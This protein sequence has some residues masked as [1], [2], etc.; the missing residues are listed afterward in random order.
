[1]I[2]PDF[3]SETGLFATNGKHLFDASVYQTDDS[4]SEFHDMVRNLSEKS[5]AAKP[6]EFHHLIAKLASE[7]RLMRLYT[8]NVDG[9]ETSLPPLNTA[10]PLHHKGPWPRTIQLHGGLQKMVCTKCSNISDFEAALFRGAT[11][12]PCPVCIEADKV[13]TDHAGKRSHGVG[14]LRP[15]MLLYN[16]HNPE[17]EAIG[18]VTEADLRTRPDA[19]I[20]VGTKMKV[21]GLKRVVR[22]MCGVVRGRKGGEAIWISR[23]PPPAGKELENC[24]DLIVQGDSDTVAAHARMR[25][26]D[27]DSI[28]Y[29]ECSESDSERAKANDS[30]VKVIIESTS[31]KVRDAASGV[32]IVVEAPAKKAAASALLTPAPSPRSKSIEPMAQLKLFPNLKALGKTDAAEKKE[33]K[34]KPPLKSTAKPLTSKD[35]A[36]KSANTK[37]PKPSKSATAAKASNMRINAAFK[38]SKPQKAP[39]LNESSAKDQKLKPAIHTGHKNRDTLRPMAPI[40]P[41]AARNNGPLLPQPARTPPKQLFPNLARQENSGVTIPPEISN[42]SV[43]STSRTPSK[44]LFPNLPRQEKSVVMIHPEI[45]KA[46]LDSESRTPLKQLF[47]NL[48]CLEDSSIRTLLQEDDTSEV[49]KPETPSTSPQVAPGSLTTWSEPHFP[50]TRASPSRP[51]YERV[52]CATFVTTKNSPSRPSFEKFFYLKT[53]CVQVNRAMSTLSPRELLPNTRTMVPQGCSPQAQ[54]ISGKSSSYGP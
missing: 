40:S 51:Y 46:P 35:K 33:P 28:D 4:T 11:P 31:S 34:S 44:Q 6:T 10:V 38:V 49:S 27:D 2:V 50:L 30:N 8:Q 25:R 7:G 52:V 16:E 5:A 15:K 19:V 41:S 13:R 45:S 43:E 23:E 24:W 3:R 42:A 54:A 14:K 53:P 26:W 18:A 36:R 12:P 29:K 9:L 32:K 48:P 20:V 39:K 47:P 21:P 22:E 37:P 1:M 17:D